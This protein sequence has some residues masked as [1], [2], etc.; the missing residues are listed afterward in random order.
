MRGFSLLLTAVAALLLFSCHSGGNDAASPNSEL[1]I[2][3]LPGGSVISTPADRGAIDMSVGQQ[4]NLRFVRTLRS[5]GLP[6]DV[7]NVTADVDVN[8]TDPDVAAVDV[9][10]QLTALESGFTVMEVI[11]RDDDLNP[12]DDDRVYLDITV[13]P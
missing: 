9:N 12:T 2:Q 11:Y 10:G 6:D 7:T 8:F 1:S 3:S 13:V 4:R 5:T